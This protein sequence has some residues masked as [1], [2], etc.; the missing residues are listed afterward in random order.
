[1]SG[2]EIFFGDQAANRSQITTVTEL[3]YPI[4]DC[5]KGTILSRKSDDWLLVS[6]LRQ[7]YNLNPLKFN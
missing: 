6:W 4:A 2:A 1:M 3:V 7:N 5:E